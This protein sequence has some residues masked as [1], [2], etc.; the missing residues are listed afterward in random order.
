MMEPVIQKIGDKLPSWK[1][2]L[3]SRPGKEMLIKS[4]LTAIPTYFL[5]VFKMTKWAFSNIDKL[6]HGFLWKGH[7]GGSM[8]GGHCLVN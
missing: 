7:D 4:V 3:L 5:I 1:R 2:G 8:S 6:R